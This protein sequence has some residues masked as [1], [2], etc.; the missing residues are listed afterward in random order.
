[1]KLLSYYLQIVL[2]IPLMVWLAK[3]DAYLFVAGLFFYVLVYRTLV[4]YFRLVDLGIFTKKTDF[5]KLLV[6]LYRIK[7]FHELYF[8]VN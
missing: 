2:P 5:W 6:P 1:M 3:L 8:K 4:D 7:V